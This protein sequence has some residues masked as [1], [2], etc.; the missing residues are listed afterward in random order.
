MYSISWEL[1]PVSSFPCFHLDMKS[2]YSTPSYEALSLKLCCCFQSLTSLRGIVLRCYFLL[3][4][5]GNIIY[6]KQKW[7]PFHFISFQLN[8]FHFV[9][10]SSLTWIYTPQKKKLDTCMRPN[11]SYSLTIKYMILYIK[12]KIKLPSSIF[13]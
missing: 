4:W 7:I 3:I 12:L 11:I 9:C 13:A 6:L 5:N 8:T 10:N 1:I 2:A